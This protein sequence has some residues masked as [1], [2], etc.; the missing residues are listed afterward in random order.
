MKRFRNYSLLVIFVL[1]S[2]KAAHHYLTAADQKTPHYFA[3][4]P[5]TQSSPPAPERPRAISGP[6]QGFVA[7][8]NQWTS[9]TPSNRLSPLLP[10]HFDT[11]P[12]RERYLFQ[13]LTIRLQRGEMEEVKK[14][15]PEIKDAE[16]K[17]SLLFRFYEEKMAHPSPMVPVNYLVPSGSANPPSDSYIYNTPTV[18]SQPAIDAAELLDLITEEVLKLESPAEP[19]T[20]PYTLSVADKAQEEAVHI[21]LGEDLLPPPEV[22]VETSPAEDQ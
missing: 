16:E 4:D 6:P 18:N 12:P 11:M 9:R 17:I 13:M 8:L 22:S 14:L 7:D 3:V 10:S 15:I 1:L 20:V 2:G 19:E 5:R 21:P